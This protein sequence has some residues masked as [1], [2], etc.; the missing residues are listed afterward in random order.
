MRTRARGALEAAER[1]F[2]AVADDPLSA[3][4]AALQLLSEDSGGQEAASVALHTVGLAAR[5]TGRLG[6]ARK[7]LKK[8]I[9]IAELGGLKE[10]AIRARLSLALVLLQDGHPE[11]ALSELA[12]AALDVPAQLRGQVLV[13]Q[14]LLH[15]RMG[16]FDDA[17][18]DSSRALPLL[19]RLPGTA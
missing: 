9:A 4:A 19:R 5:E 17:L 10:R 3:E 8:A 6:I 11:A 13:Q 12:L 14:A 2:D 7:R 15:I 16:R 1:A 18:D